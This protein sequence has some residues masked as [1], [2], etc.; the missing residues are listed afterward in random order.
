MR[1][2]MLAMA[3]TCAL[4]AGIG[5]ALANEDVKLKHIVVDHSDAARQRGA[6]TI[7]S[8]CMLCHSLKY[9]HF[10]DLTDIGMG[11]TQIEDLLTDQKIGDS[12]MSLSP[13]EVRKE[14]YGKVPPDL[15]LM[16]IAREKGPDYIYSLLTGFY[17]TED[18][19]SDNHIF[20]GI[21]M[22]D[23]LGYSFTEPG[24]E[25]R[26]QIEAQARDVVSF[27]V[28]AAD[29]SAEERE[30]IGVYVIIYLVILTILLYL[31]KRRVWRR[32]PEFTGG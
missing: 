19:G 18:G 9:V 31:V 14:S 5:T 25:D 29:P 11:K 23:P 16:A 21:K 3:T 24:S 4:L 15:S 2:L 30:S 13:V 7:T 20:P 27:L 28:W 22:P 17:N 8:T 12:M 26:A 6:E 10:S 1:R 32:L